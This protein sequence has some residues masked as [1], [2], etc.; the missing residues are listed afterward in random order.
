[1]SSKGKSNGKVTGK[2]KAASQS[3]PRA[4]IFAIDL[5]AEE[6]KTIRVPGDFWGGDAKQ[7]FVCD[8]LKN[9][10]DYEFPNLR[11]GAVSSPENDVHCDHRSCYMQKQNKNGAFKI[12][13]RGVGGEKPAWIN[14][15]KYLMYKNSAAL[16]DRSLSKEIEKCIAANTAESRV[17]IQSPNSSLIL[18]SDSAALS[19][20]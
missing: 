2:R 15:E 11:K 12:L 5:S 16:N 1:M 10:K 20:P 19:L 3:E 7:V 18:L 9:D 4:N 14:P 8:V 17:D 13:A 6:K